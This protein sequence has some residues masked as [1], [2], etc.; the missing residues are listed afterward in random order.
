MMQWGDPKF[1]ESKNPNISHD[2]YHFKEIRALLGYFLLT[3]AMAYAVV[4]G[5]VWSLPHIISLEREKS[6]F[7][8]VQT[9]F[10]ADGTIRQDP[11]LQQLANQL[12]A[13]M[14]LPEHAITVYYSQDETPNAFATFGGNIVINRGLLQ[15]L[16]SEESV[17]A[18]LAHEMAHI[19]HR[20][21]LR[22]MSRGLLYSLIAALFGSD[23]QMQTLA[24]LEGLRY[25]RELEYQADAAALDA[26][27]R[28][29]R[30]TQGMHDLF[31]ELAKM[32]QEY[33]G[34]HRPAWL[35]THPATDQRIRQ[36]QR[37]SQ[38]LTPPK[39]PDTH[40][41]PWRTSKQ[42]VQNKN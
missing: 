38:E 6:W 40:D 35:S 34:D 23:A 32:E 7:G 33:G 17:A 9:R 28:Q 3:V 1:D 31:A 37:R 22:G 36:I 10:E 16:P 11:Q 25:S 42:P 24:N 2:D 18:V 12:A 13:H 20:D 15:R 27:Y 14:K 39:L 4:E 30:H 26:V 5:L 41:N 29:Y 21:P 8:F 19:R